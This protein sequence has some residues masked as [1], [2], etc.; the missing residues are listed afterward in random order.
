MPWCSP[1][2]SA[3]QCWCCRHLEANPQFPSLEVGGGTAEQFQPMPEDAP[4]LI[5]VC[6]WD[7]PAGGTL[8][9]GGDLVGGLWG[10]QGAAGGGSVPLSH[11]GTPQ[12]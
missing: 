12:P 11:Q 3:Q 2:R 9:Y 10:Q 6:S 4:G 1:L 7:R 8:V 5:R